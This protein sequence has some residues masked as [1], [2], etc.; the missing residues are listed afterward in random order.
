MPRPEEEPTTHIIFRNGRNGVLSPE[1]A[2]VTDDSVF[3]PDQQIY[4]PRE[5]LGKTKRPTEGE[6]N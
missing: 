1:F 6:P 5:E 4:I 3:D 2:G